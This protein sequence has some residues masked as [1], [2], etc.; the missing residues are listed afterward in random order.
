MSSV[1]KSPKVKKVQPPVEVVPEVADNNAIEFE[2]EK[3]RK[4]KMGAISQML[5]RENADGKKHTLG[6]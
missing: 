5:S 4:R 6:A 2:L 3:K 1:F